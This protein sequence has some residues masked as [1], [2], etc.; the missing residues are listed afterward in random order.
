MICDVC[1]DKIKDCCNCDCDCTCSKCS[2]SHCCTCCFCCSC[3]PGCPCCDCTKKRTYEQHVITRDNNINNIYPYN[4]NANN[5]GFVNIGE[6][7]VHR[8]VV[9]PYPQNQN[10]VLTIYLKY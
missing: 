5:K 9:N 10:V 4:I 7:S 3:C 1:H 2:C 6:S 8:M